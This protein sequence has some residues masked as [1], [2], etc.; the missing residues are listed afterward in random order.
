MTMNQTDNA[1]LHSRT[2]G[3]VKGAMGGNCENGEHHKNHFHRVP[4]PLN[5]VQAIRPS[6]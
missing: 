6:G 4:H 3:A 2:G 1:H 5:A